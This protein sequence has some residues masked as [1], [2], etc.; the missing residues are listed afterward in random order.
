[1][2]GELEGYINQL[3]GLLSDL[4]G[5]PD[6]LNSSEGKTVCAV[7]EYLTMLRDMS[8]DIYDLVGYNIDLYAALQAI[9]NLD[10]NSEDYAALAAQISQGTDTALK[11]MDK[12]EPPAYLAISHSDL[13]KRIQEFKDFSVDFSAAIEISDPLRI[14]SCFFRMN[15]IMIAFTR[16]GDNLNED[17][18]LQFEQANRRLNGPIATLNDELSHNLELLKAA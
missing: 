7:R 17:I 11:I 3:D 14:Y 10:S 9:G 1:M 16:C 4:N 5:L 8:A 12:I 2:R 15:R 18:K 6:D 13:E